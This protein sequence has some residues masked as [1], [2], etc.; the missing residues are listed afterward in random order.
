MLDII[1]F[2]FQGCFIHFHLSQ[3]SELM[4]VPAFSSF[5]HPFQLCCFPCWL[6]RRNCHAVEWGQMCHELP[7]TFPLNRLALPHLC[8]YALFVAL[9]RQCS[10]NSDRLLLS[11]L[12]DICINAVWVCST[13]W[14][15][16]GSLVCVLGFCSL[17]ISAFC[18]PSWDCPLPSFMYL[19]L[20]FLFVCLGASAPAGFSPVV[21]SGGAHCVCNE[22]RPSQEFILLL[23]GLRAQAR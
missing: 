23:A 17:N 11:H 8:L 3:A 20:A 13:I 14:I 2:N 15:T 21:A 10:L 1:S 4:E 22:H 5:T 12:S 19:V 9:L 18:L 6:T 7:L 16:R